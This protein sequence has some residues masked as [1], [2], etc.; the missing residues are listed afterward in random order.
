MKESVSIDKFSVKLLDT[1]NLF[2]AKADELSQM[3]I[4]S[5]PLFGGEAAMFLMVFLAGLMG[6]LAGAFDKEDLTGVG[7]YI[8]ILVLLLVAVSSFRKRKLTTAIDSASKMV[9][10]NKAGIGGTGL[11]ASKKEIACS[12]V[13]QIVIERFAKGYFGGYGV[14]LITSQ[15]DKAFITNQNLEFEDAQKCAESVR[16]FIN[17]EEKIVVTG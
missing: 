17:L 16:E 4:Q 13:K 8:V 9:T 12:G 10:L 11:F 2:V 6:L 1:H 14:K 7:A 5:E 3:R 15:G